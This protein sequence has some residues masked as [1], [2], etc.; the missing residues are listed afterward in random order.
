ESVFA[1]PLSL[2]R[3]V[4]DQRQRQRGRKLYSLH[5]PEVECIGKG[6]AHKPYEFGVKVS[7]ATPLNRCR[8]GQFVAHVKAL[9]GNP[10]DGHT[11][12]AVLPDIESTIGAGLERIVTDAGDKG[13]NAPKHQRFKVYV[14]GQKR[15]LT[16]AIKRA[17]RRRSAVEP[18]IG[19]LKNEHRMGRNYLA[20]RAGDAA[21]AVPGR[22]GGAAP[23]VLAA[24]GSNFALPL[25]WPALLRRLVRAALAAPSHSNRTI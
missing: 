1:R 2:A 15:G 4:K 14:A 25:R 5:A 9:P 17:F 23:P 16:A 13:P 18:T 8:G 24:V 11:L 21:N 6:K 12:A 22:A 19:H 10:Y 3:R 20:G 7:V